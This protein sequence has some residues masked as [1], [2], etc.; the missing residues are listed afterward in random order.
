MSKFRADV[1]DS[2]SIRDALGQNQTLA[3][4]RA[5]IRESDER[6]ACIR[7]HLPP[8]MARHVRAGPLDESGWSILVDNAAIASKL[9]QLEP[10]LRMQLE[11]R[12][13]AVVAI[14][15]KIQAR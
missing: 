9:R 13:M 11:S 10:T 15:I 2:L 7:Q 5:R 1:P 12:G 4:L 6:L 3:S 8:A 14:R